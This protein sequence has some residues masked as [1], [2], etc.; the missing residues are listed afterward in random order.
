V[1]R[2]ADRWLSNLAVVLAIVLAFFWSLTAKRYFDDFGT[3]FALLRGQ[4][5]AGNV[6]GNQGVGTLSKGM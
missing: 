2:V 1:C 4:S 3:A 6:N 5:A